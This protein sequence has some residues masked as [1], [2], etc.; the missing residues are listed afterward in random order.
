MDYQSFFFF[1]V[2]TL[3]CKMAVLTLFDFKICMEEAFL[4]NLMVFKKLVSEL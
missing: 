3:L 2:H 4:S 1:A